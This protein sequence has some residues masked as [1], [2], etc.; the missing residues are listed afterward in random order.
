MKKLERVKSALLGKET[1]RIPFALWRHFPVIDQTSQGLADSHVEFVKKYDFDF[2][3]VTP[4]NGFLVEDWGVKFKYEGA[5]D[6]TREY[7][8]R[9]IKSYLDLRKLR[10]NSVKEGVLCRELEALKFIRKKVKNKIPILQTIFSPLTL[11]KN[12]CGDLLFSYMRKHSDELKR[13]LEI[14]S[15]TVRRFAISCLSCGA[16]GLFFA[17]QMA[18]R[19]FLSREEYKE[20]EEYYNLRI[21]RE[22]KEKTGLLIF[23]IHGEEIFF[24]EISKYPVGALNWHTQSTP[25][26]LSIASEKT[27]KCLVGGL[28][29][30]KTLLD[31]NTN[32]IEEETMKAIRVMK[33]KRLIIS[34]GCVIPVDTPKENIFA[35]KRIIEKIGSGGWI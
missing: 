23:H 4:T 22:L 9:P 3:K 2:L 19:K 13:A 6:G 15:E 16:D 33:G 29:E 11:A 14:I 12:L 26:S 35:V 20:F 24:E 34:A 21:I 30:W 17:T 27:K 7:V 28:D 25:P 32:K 5:L 1:D 18:S 31:R 10:V 8:F